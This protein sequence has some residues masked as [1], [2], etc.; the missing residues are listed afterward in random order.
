[1]DGEV[2]A[3]ALEDATVLPRALLPELRPEEAEPAPPR[4]RVQHEER[5]D[6]RDEGRDR[7]EQVPQRPPDA[8]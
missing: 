6:P 2:L 7:E 4:G 8:A 1:V 3:D 5:Q